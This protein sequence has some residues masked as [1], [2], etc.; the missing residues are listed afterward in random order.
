MTYS[1]SKQFAPP[2]VDLRQGR[3]LDDS[4]DGRNAQHHLKHRDPS[5]VSLRDLEYYF[6]VWG[7]LDPS[8]LIFYLHSVLRFA[9]GVEN[10]PVYYER[11]S[12]T[13]DSR[14]NQIVEDLTNVQI[15]QLRTAL[16]DA[17]SQQELEFLQNLSDFVNLAG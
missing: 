13:L 11:W 2:K 9:Q 10:T 3:I 7:F 4:G 16:V 5:D 17:I 8:D 15:E 1:L 14:L 6:D 12:E